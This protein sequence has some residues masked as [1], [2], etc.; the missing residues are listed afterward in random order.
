[1]F[2]FIVSSIYH[3]CE[4]QIETIDNVK[5]YEKIDEFEQNLPP[6]VTV[7]G[8]SFGSK[9]LLKKFK[10]LKTFLGEV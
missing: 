9:V 7:L 8:N 2:N 3:A 4:N 10:I 6:T 1:M 5:V